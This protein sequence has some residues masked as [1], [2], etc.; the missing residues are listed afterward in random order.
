MRRRC[1]GQSLDMPT[2]PLLQLTAGDVDNGVGEAREASDVF[3]HTPLSCPLGSMRNVKIR[4]ELYRGG[5]GW[6]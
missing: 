3:S 4:R 6:S 2:L 5:V 1:Y